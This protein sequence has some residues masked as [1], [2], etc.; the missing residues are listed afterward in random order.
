M[1]LMDDL[2]DDVVVWT[3]RP[4]LVSETQLAL[5]NAIRAA[6]RLGKFWRDVVTTTVIP[7][8]S[9][10]QSI[11]LTDTCPNMRQ[12]KYVKNVDTDFAFTEIDASDLLDHDGFRK[13]GVYWA[14]GNA[15]SVRLNSSTSA[16]EIAYYQQP[17]TN[18]PVL[19][20]LLDQYRDVVILMAAGTVLGIIGEQEIK[21]RVDALFALAAQDLISDNIEATGR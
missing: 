7:V 10:I 16:L 2:V 8:D 14:M 13:D 9:Q 4:K 6:H 11:N 5:R 3:N 18:P 17:A 12:L 20:W 15:L 21:S 19:D 1:A